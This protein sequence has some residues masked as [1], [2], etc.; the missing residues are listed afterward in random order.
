MS[1]ENDIVAA[2]KNAAKAVSI[3]ED[4]MRLFESASEQHKQALTDVSALEDAHTLYHSARNVETG[5]NIYHKFGLPHA[6]TYRA[7]AEAIRN[8]QLAETALIDARA[9]AHGALKVMSEYEALRGLKN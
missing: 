2:V 6:L 1:A 8:K 5:D 9:K 3:W 4:A 7:V